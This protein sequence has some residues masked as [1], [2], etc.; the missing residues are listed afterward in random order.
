[1]AGHPRGFLCSPDLTYPEEWDRD[2]CPVTGT[3]RWL[4]VGPECNQN[5]L[6]KAGA[7]LSDVSG[8]VWPDVQGSSA[9][10]LRTDVKALNENCQTMTTISIA[11]PA[12]PCAIIDLGYYY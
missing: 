2:F 3:I 9:S 5:E 10:L 4:S 11:V 8:I 12:D 6:H 1:L 7:A